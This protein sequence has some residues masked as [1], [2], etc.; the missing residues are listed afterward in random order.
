MK[1]PIFLLLASFL[2]CAPALDDTDA[3]RRQT[4]YR[5][6]RQHLVFLSAYYGVF[7]PVDAAAL[8]QF[9][10]PDAT[11]TDP[12]FELRIAGRREIGAVLVSALKKYDHLEQQVVHAISARD[13]LVVEGLMV[14]TLRGKEL[15]VHFVSVF[16]IE[17]GKIVAQRDLYDVRHYLEQL[18]G[19]KAGEQP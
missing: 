14:A 17:G 2:S 7:N 6:T 3:L 12:S 18:R 9:Y 5:V 10:A 11:L 1:F 19:G 13:E 8:E 4:R 15:R 16:R